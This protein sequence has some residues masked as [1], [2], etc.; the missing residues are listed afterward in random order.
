MGYSG[1]NTPQLGV[2]F[3]V[4]TAVHANGNVKGLSLQRWSLVTTL[5][6]IRLEALN[7]PCE[8]NFINFTV[9]SSHSAKQKSSK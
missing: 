6:L 9:P 3:M 4:K 8:W 5:F 2:I 7:F 1:P